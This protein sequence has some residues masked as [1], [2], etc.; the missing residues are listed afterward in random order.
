MWRG[1]RSRL[2]R[3]CPTCR[4]PRTERPDRPSTGMIIRPIALA[5]LVASSTALVAS[6]SFDVRSPVQLRLDN[7]A[8]RELQWRSLGP[9]NGDMLS[10]AF[11]TSFPYR[12]CGVEQTRGALCV[13]SLGTD[14][15]R[16]AAVGVMAL[17]GR[18]VR[19][20]PSDSDVLFGGNLVRY[21][22]RL[23]Q[24][25]PVTPPGERVTETAA[26]APPVIV[27]GPDGKTLYY[28]ARTLWRTTTAGQSWTVASTETFG[29]G[30]TDTISAVAFS[31]VSARLI[32]AGTRD[33]VMQLSQDGGASWTRRPSP[34]EAAQ[35]SPVLAIE[36]SHFDVN[37][38]YVVLDRA[39]VSLPSAFRTRD[40]GETWK[41]L[42]IALTSGRVYVIREDLFRRGLLF[43][44][45]D[46]GPLISYDDGESWSPLALNLPRAPIR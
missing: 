12:V 40:G 41:V 11:D 16:T 39:D 20:D 35:A 25:V 13:S 31:P 5:V 32:W 21:D 9:V 23:E 22:R 45:T 17:G 24:V 18:M 44:G 1:C 36:G 15:G 29:S 27:F 30:P 19:P 14:A 6:S 34:A 3:P 2:P 28:G 7:A 42:P 43:A 26:P 46:A 10:A 4:T 8:L 33:G 38:A 37:S